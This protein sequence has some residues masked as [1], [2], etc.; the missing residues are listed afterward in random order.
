MS[1]WSVDQKTDN[2]MQTWSSMIDYLMKTGEA[3]WS[4]VIIPD[5]D[6]CGTAKRSV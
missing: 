1:P 6:F 4:L 3:V 5:S 2:R